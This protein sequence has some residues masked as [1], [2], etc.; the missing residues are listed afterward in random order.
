MLKR[1]SSAKTTI[2]AIVVAVALSLG[3]IYFYGNYQYK[4]G[5]TD[6]TITFYEADKKGAKSVHETAKK[7]IRDIGIVDNDADADR[8]LEQTDGFRD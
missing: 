4:S 7:I 1:L 6:A 3:S 2:I 5:V 8:L